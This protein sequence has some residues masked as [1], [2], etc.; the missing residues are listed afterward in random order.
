[1]SE[2][3]EDQDKIE[4]LHFE[5]EID[6]YLAF[7]KGKLIQ[8]CMADILGISADDIIL[9][10]P[11]GFES[12]DR[13]LGLFHCYFMTKLRVM[14][15]FVEVFYQSL[16][17]GTLK[18]RIT[19][20]TLNIRELY[21]TEHNEMEAKDNNSNM[22]W[23]AVDERGIDHMGQRTIDAVSGFIRT[24]YDENMKEC[25]QCIEWAILKY[26][27]YPNTEFVVYN[28]SVPSKDLSLY[29]RIYGH[30]VIDG[31]EKNKLYVW[32]FVIDYAGEF[33]LGIDEF[34]NHNEDDINGRSDGEQTKFY[35]VSNHNSALGVTLC[36]EM[37]TGDAIQMALCLSEPSLE[38]WICRRDETD[39]YKLPCR[40]EDLQ[41]GN[42][43]FLMG[44]FIYS[45]SY[46]R[47]RQ[48]WEYDIDDNNR[49]LRRTVHAHDQYP[50][51][52]KYNAVV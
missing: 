31:N 36:A 1:M 15:D 49:K 21:S 30:L 8:K 14:E 5:M 51:S 20:N 16:Q 7:E 24:L 25:P 48:C 11:Q 35:G 10:A 34:I 50:T 32:E 27:F 44:I 37:K 42:T 43:K 9:E 47:L 2:S 52:V 22:Q 45:C 28:L 19:A 33:M 26:Y 41:L 46:V 4:E 38:F 17:N 40:I 29:E 39:H 23:I 6:F 13:T 18:E 12:N 3:Q